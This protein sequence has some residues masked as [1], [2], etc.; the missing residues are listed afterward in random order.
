V[1]FLGPDPGDR[2]GPDLLE[3]G[4]ERSWRP[5]R[6]LWPA[7]LVIAVAGAAVYGVLR[8]PSTGHIPPEPVVVHSTGRR[9]LGVRS[10]WELFGRGQGA[11]VAI[12]LAAGQI[13]TTRVP[14]LASNSPEVA[15]I[16]GPRSVIIR[17]F[18]DVPG[19]VVPDGLPPRPLT[20]A[21]AADQ[22]GPLLPGPRPGQTWVMA[23]SVQTASLLLLGPDGRPTGTVARLPPDEALPA[24]AIPDG[25]GDVLLL[26]DNNEIYDASSTGYWQVHAEIVAVGPAQWLGFTCHG[27][28]HC[29]DVVID[30]ATGTQ[31]ALPSAAAAPELEAA[32]AW[33]SLGVTAPDGQLAAVPVYGRGTGVTVQLVSLRTGV[34]TQVDARLA[35][36]PGYQFMA[37]SPDSRWLFAAGADGK[38]V[39]IDARTGRVA[40]LGVPLPPL[41]QVAV[42]AGPGSGP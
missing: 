30:P 6:W 3:V 23:G 5:P 15:F 28:G 13:T 11:L 40:S 24:T 16:V 14:P 9:L 12:D 35:P 21:L 27:Q 34:S 32:F 38:L 22:P 25:R 42:R 4:S 26:T 37:W 36:S 8:L 41:T 33:P 7:L 17:S 39:V 18:D 29:R 10:G 19:Y 1:T 2:D 31:R 20:G